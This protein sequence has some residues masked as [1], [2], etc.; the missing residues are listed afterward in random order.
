M[1]A[2]SY[3]AKQFSRFSNMVENKTDEKNYGNVATNKE[4]NRKAIFFFFLRYRDKLS[5]LSFRLTFLINII[6]MPWESLNI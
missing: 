6:V 4:N 3:S 5:V 1:S 2:K